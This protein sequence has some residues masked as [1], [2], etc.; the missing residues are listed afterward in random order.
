VL[1]QGG[2]PAEALISNRLT[3]RAV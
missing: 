3:T 2:S 1:N